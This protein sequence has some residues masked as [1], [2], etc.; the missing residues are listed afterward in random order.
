M[1]AAAGDSVGED[2]QY[3][4]GVVRASPRSKPT[5]DGIAG[6]PLRMIRAD[7]I[8]AITSEVPEAALEAG[9]DELLTHSAVLEQ[10][11]SH[12]TVLPMQFGVIMPSVDAVRDQLLEAHRTELEEQLD[13]MDGRIEVNLKAL[14]DEATLLREVVAEDREIASLKE[15]VAGL[16]AEAAHFESMR[17]GE[18]V[19]AAVNAKREADAARILDLLTPLAAASE[20]GDPIHEYMVVNASFLL[21][22]A[23]EQ[24]FDGALERLAADQHPRIRFKL[25]GPLPPH[26][27]V[28]LSVRA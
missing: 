18:M 2:A 8:G 12:G 17:L 1:A 14:Y 21:E 10:A 5:G 23:R 7:G 3:V 4:Y 26:S 16:P 19:A 20:V 11:L 6:R 27:F 28:E 9:R 15:K 13:A 25:T 24:E 22:S